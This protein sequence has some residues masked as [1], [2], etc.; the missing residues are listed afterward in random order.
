MSSPCAQKTPSYEPLVVLKTPLCAWPVPAGGI[1]K[2]SKFLSFAPPRISAISPWHWQ[3]QHLLPS[4]ATQSARLLPS[5]L[6][7]EPAVGTQSSWLSL[8]CDF[9]TLSSEPPILCLMFLCVR[10]TPFYVVL[11]CLLLR[12]YAVTKIVGTNQELLQFLLFV[13]PGCF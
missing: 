4:C 2:P 11:D 12:P 9:P 3:A 1:Q 8:P 10:L 5:S 13:L 7:P 6:F